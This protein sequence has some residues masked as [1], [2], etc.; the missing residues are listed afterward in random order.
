[1]LQLCIL[2]CVY[3]EVEVRHMQDGWSNGARGKSLLCEP[4]H[5]LIQLRVETC[6]DTISLNVS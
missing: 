1:M 2:G 5:G 6:T 4:P 3:W